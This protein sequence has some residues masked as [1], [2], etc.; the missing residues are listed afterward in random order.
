MIILLISVSEVNTMTY[1]A[2]ILY[3]NLCLSVMLDSL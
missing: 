1:I 3:I 2:V